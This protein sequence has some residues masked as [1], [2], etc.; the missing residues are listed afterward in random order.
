MSPVLKLLQTCHRKTDS[1][2][3]SVQRGCDGNLV[4]AAAFFQPPSD[5]FLARLRFSPK[6]RYPIGRPAVSFAVC[7]LNLALNLT[8]QAGDILRG[9]AGSGAIA[10]HGL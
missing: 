1:A 3:A 10:W 7:F 5:M 9:G 2:W 4:E 8:G 6:R